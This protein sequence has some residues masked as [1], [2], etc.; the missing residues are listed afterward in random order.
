MYGGITELVWVSVLGKKTINRPHRLNNQ[1][2]YA[3]NK[4]LILRYDIVE[5]GILSGHIRTVLRGDAKTSP[6]DVT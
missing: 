5:L 6:F 4:E 3:Y 2:S 1:P